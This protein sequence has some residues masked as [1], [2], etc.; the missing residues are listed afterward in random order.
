M[1]QSHVAMQTPET[2]SAVLAAQA[3]ALVEARYLIAINRPRDL[4]VVREKLVDRDSGH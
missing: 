3:R 4:D 1:V 2:A